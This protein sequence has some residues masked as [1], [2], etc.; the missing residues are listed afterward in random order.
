[1]GGKDAG[2]QLWTLDGFRLELAGDRV[3]EYTAFPVATAPY[4]VYQSLN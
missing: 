3:M 2:V 4:L 1:M